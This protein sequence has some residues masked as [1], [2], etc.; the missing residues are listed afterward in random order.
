M[1]SFIRIWIIFWDFYYFWDYSGIS[2]FPPPEIFAEEA[3]S[4]LQQIL[5]PWFEMHA[6]SCWW[7]LS[8]RWLK[9]YEFVFKWWIQVKELH[10]FSLL[11][12][13][14]FTSIAAAG[15]CQGAESSFKMSVPTHQRGVFVIGRSHL[16]EPL[17]SKLHFSTVIHQKLKDHGAEYGERDSCT[18]WITVYSSNFW[19]ME[20]PRR[21]LA[22][23]NKQYFLATTGYGTSSVMAAFSA[24]DVEWV[25]IPLRAVRRG[26]IY[27]FSVLF[28]FVIFLLFN[29]SMW[30]CIWTCGGYNRKKKESTDISNI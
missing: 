17:W 21:L 22:D 10:C 11:I 25:Q 15:G 20:E 1:V 19:L 6:S 14:S 8:T 16:W 3:S 24:V 2:H 23:P 9:R 18:A 27:N 30:E 28:F 5:A 7:A 12:K 26:I 4:S 13:V 29:G